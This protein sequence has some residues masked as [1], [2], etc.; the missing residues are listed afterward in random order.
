MKFEVRPGVV[1]TVATDAVVIGV[2]EGDGGLSGAAAEL[3]MALGGIIKDLISSGEVKGKLNEIHAMHTLGK[4]PSRLAVVA[5]MGKQA[6]WDTDKLRD[7]AG[8]A[9]R[10]LRRHRAGSAA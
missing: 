7:V 1:N 4:I 9:V 10:A 3:D 8:E 5:G 2:F 6:E